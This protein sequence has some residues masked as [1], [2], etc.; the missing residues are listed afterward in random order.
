MQD[1][2]LHLLDVVENS[3]RAGA[4]AVRVLVMEDRAL[5]RLVLEVV[6]DGPGMD[7]ETAARALDPLF[8]TK[9]DKVYGLGLPMLAQE[10]RVAVGRVTLGRGDPGGL[11][12]R[13]EFRLSHPDCR[14]LGDLEGTVAMMQS[15]HPEVEF[16]YRHTVTGAPEETR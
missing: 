3:L 7:P 15:A 9:P 4:S 5:D 2:S 12:V 6:D 16:R 8:T 1:L 10:A 14:P 11:R 13:A